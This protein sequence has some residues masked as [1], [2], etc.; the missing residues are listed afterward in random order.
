VPTLIRVATR[1]EARATLV[2]LLQHTRSYVQG[3]ADANTE[4]SASIIESARLAVK[5]TPVHPP[6][7][8]RRMRW[9][10][11]FGPRR[12]AAKV[13]PALFFSSVSM[14]VINS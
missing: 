3:Q 7:A 8:G 13:V 14:H 10:P 4:N 9:T 5:K 6:R 11:L 1:N 2:G 12:S